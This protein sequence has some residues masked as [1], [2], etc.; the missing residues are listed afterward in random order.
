MRARVNGSDIVE[1]M[2]TDKRALTE[3][4]DVL[5]D[6]AFVLNANDL[7]VSALKFAKAIISGRSIANHGFNAPI[8]V[9]QNVP[10]GEI[11][12]GEYVTVDLNGFSSSSKVL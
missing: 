5:K 3:Y 9:L 4:V 2:D 7:S 8:V 12:Y 10:N 11:A 6:D 1:L